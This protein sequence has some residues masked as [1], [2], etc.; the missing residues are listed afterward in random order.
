MNGITVPPDNT[1]LDYWAS[2][3]EHSNI[4]RRDTGGGTYPPYPLKGNMYCLRIYNRQLTD[5]QLTH[6]A[7]LDQK[8]YLSPPVVTIDDKPCTEV[9]VLSDHFLMCK[10]PPGKVDIT[11][12][13]TNSSVYRFAKVFEYR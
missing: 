5:E 12:S 10:V 13:L 9:V 4:G 2:G 1:H 8:R 6:N 7:E 11:I 3:A